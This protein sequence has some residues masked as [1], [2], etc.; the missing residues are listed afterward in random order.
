MDLAS[1]YHV[2]ADGEWNDA[3]GEHLAALEDSHFD[4]P[5]HVGLV[6]APERVDAAMTEFNVLR[7]PTTW[8]WEAVGWEQ[9]TLA[10][11]H[12]YAQEHD[13]AVMYGHTKGAANGNPFQAMWRRWMTSHVIAGWRSHARCLDGGLYDA[14]GCHWLTQEEFPHVVVDTDFPMFGG[15]FWI[16]TC[17]Y[18]RTL[19]PVGMNRRHEAESWIGL[20]A[21][22]VVDLSP[23]WPGSWPYPH[24]PLR[25]LVV[26]R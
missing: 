22:R 8:W 4:G 20:G 19:P 25:K 11:V 18:L 1:F 9:V 21:P 17:K 10:K 3:V 5:F 26:A 6:G 13:G 7:P 23:G 24:Q 2:Y 12:E 15:N 16:A 14:I